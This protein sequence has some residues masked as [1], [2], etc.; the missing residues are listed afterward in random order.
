MDNKELIEDTQN[1]IDSLTKIREESNRTVISLNKIIADYTN[2]RQI[3]KKKQIQLKKNIN[4]LKNK[5]DKL[6]ELE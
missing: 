5:L 3:E 1:R 6:N 4:I 2:S